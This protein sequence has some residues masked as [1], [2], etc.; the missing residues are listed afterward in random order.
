MPECLYSGSE[1]SGI[2]NQ[3]LATADNSNYTLREFLEYFIRGTLS[4]QMSTSTSNILSAIGGISS[5]LSGVSWKST[6]LSVL[7]QIQSFRY[8][9]DQM[10]FNSYIFDPGKQFPSIEGDL[11]YNFSLEITAYNVINSTPT[12]VF[13]SSFSESSENE[14]SLRNEFTTIVM[15]LGSGYCKLEGYI[16]VPFASSMTNEEKKDLFTILVKNNGQS[17]L[18]S[19]LL[20]SQIQK[21]MSPSWADWIVQKSSPTEGDMTIFD[22]SISSLPSIIN[23]GVTTLALFQGVVNNAFN[24]LDLLFDLLNALYESIVAYQ[25]NNK[26]D[27]ILECEFDFKK[28][29]RLLGDALNYAMKDAGI[30]DPNHTEEYMFPVVSRNDQQ[31]LDLNPDGQAC[32][33]WDGGLPALVNHRQYNFKKVWCVGELQTDPIPYKVYII[34]NW[35]QDVPQMCAPA[36]HPDLIYG[37]NY[38]K[39]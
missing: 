32:L 23:L 2:I 27:R 37:V 29:N 7:Q 12:V 20:L 14:Y 4:S 18:N 31:Y 11:Y 10:V 21:N 17:S 38:G 36:D 15:Q 13:T 26:L 8:M 6:L 5:N 39:V 24:W 22:G 25:E 16:Y 35:I 28:F 30:A 9:Y 34:P 33:D 3:L 1:V 19:H